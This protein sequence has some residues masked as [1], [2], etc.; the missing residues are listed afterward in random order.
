MK[1]LFN[2][3]FGSFADIGTD[4][5]DVRFAPRNDI[6]DPRR[7]REVGH[8]LPTFRKAHSASRATTSPPTTAVCFICSTGCAG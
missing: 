8:F 1:N 5:K 6:A 7:P 4:L 3:S 2:V